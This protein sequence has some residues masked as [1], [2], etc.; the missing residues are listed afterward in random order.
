MGNVDKRAGKFFGP[1]VGKTLIYFMDDL[2]MPYVDKYGTQSPICL[3]RQI[4]DHGIVY[5]REHLEEQKALLDVMFTACMN[6]KGGSFFVDMRLT[7]H[8]TMISCVTAD[9]EILAQ[10]YQQ[11]LQ[12]HFESFD[13]SFVEMP[14]R[15][16]TAT[17]A[18]FTQICLAP[19]FFPTARK[20]HYQFNLRD[21]AR[22]VQNLLLSE[23]QPYK[24]N[25]KDVARMWVHECNRV[26]RDRLIFDVD[27]DLYTGFIKAALK[28]LGDFKEDELLAEPNLY[29]SYVSSCEGH[30]AQYL[31]VRDMAQL[32]RVLEAKLEEYCETVASMNL[33]LF[34]VAMEHVSR[35]ARILFNPVGS[36]LLVGVGGS[37]K[38]SL[39]KLSAFILGLEVCR[40][41]VTTTYGMAEL[42]EDMR[43][44]FTKAGQGDINL[45][46]LLTDTQITN[47]KFLVPMNDMLSQ[48]YIPELFPVDDLEQIL[49]KV[50]PFA[51]AAGCADQKDEIFGFFVDRVRKNLHLALCC[52]PV[53]DTLRFRARKFPAIINC[54]S[55]DWFHEWPQDALIDVAGRFLAEVKFPDVKNNGGEVVDVNAQIAQHM[56]FV[57]LRIGEANEE[58]RKRERRNNYTTP[59][60]FLELISFYKLLLG[61]K[62]DKI[63]DQIKRLE[64]GL[65]TMAGTT[66]QVA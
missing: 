11:I 47:E 66:A 41:V 14:R 60:S 15:L 39:S 46:F 29:T 53:G 27:R 7:R 24:N 31:P 59:T 58:F 6:P 36:A 50:R 28:E 10:I 43:G 57:H 23:P 48:G 19:S 64:V 17:S 1:P 65:E 3:V 40:I 16:V 30:E 42:L 56:A 51:K 38:Q 33:V 4:I 5:D 34:G 63:N 49:N 35:I 37:G 45:M 2:N 25:T 55:L 8:L 21:Y 32:K 18:I 20:F 54:T 26:W 44:F 13:K 12:A 62:R 52:S 61:Q 9:K 22:I